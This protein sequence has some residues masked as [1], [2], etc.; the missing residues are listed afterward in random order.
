MV[1]LIILRADGRT[2]F[3]SPVLH[4]YTMYLL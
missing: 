1:I 2:L 3:Y 4:T